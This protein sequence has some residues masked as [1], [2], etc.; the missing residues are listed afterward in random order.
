MQKGPILSGARLLR[1]AEIMSREP[2]V[3]SPNVRVW[4]MH[5][6]ERSRTNLVEMSGKLSY[7]AHPDADHTL[8]VLSGCVC[9]WVDREAVVLNEGDYLSIP[10]SV[11][12]KYET[13]TKTALLVSFDAPAYDPAKQV[14]IP[15]DGV[16][17]A[18]IPDPV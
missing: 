14:R 13:I 15:E 10:A 2:H 3:Q 16:D 8:M 4:T 12:H 5:Q 6:D 7:H 9:A 1:R 17:F 18:P 11:P